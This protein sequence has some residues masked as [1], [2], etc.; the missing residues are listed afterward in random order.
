[1]INCVGAGKESSA[2]NALSQRI[3]SDVTVTTANTPHINE[4]TT[5]DIMLLTINPP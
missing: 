5:R 2:A 1:V 4:E 3:T